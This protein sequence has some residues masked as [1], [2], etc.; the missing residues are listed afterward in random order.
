MTKWVFNDGG[1]KDAGFSG[2]TGDC[3]C[4]A[5]ATATGCTY[6]QVYLA[7]NHLAQFERTGKRKKKVSNARTGVYTQMIPKLLTHL[8]IAFEWVPCMKIGS[9]CTVH[10]RADELPTGKLILN[11]SRHISCMLDGVVHDT[12]DPSREGTRCVYGYWRI[13]D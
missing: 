7:I 5:I 6:H 10:V 4:R 8:G 11:L 12:Y 13:L 9:G 1:R 2:T 3:A